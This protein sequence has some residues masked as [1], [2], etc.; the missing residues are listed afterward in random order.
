MAREKQQYDYFTENNTISAN[1]IY[2]STIIANNI[3]SLQI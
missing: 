3:F 2:I 1:N